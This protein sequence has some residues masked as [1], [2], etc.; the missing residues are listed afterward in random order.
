MEPV[1]TLGAVSSSLAPWPSAL[2]AWLLTRSRPQL[3]EVAQVIVSSGLFQ[4][5]FPATLTTR[6]PSPDSNVLP[7]ERIAPAE[8][9]RSKTPVQTSAPVIPNNHSRRV[10]RLR[11]FNA[12]I[13]CSPSFDAYRVWVGALTTHVGS[14]A[15]HLSPLAAAARAKALSARNPQAATRCQQRRYVGSEH[16]IRAPGPSGR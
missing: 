13:L 11:N 1:T 8:P 10:C 9:T 5:A 14:A 7:P 3:T 16:P 12:A 6:L 2:S 15:D 4:S